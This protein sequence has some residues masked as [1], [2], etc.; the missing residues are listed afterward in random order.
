[1]KKKEARSSPANEDR[2]VAD[3]P[4][5]R[6]RAQA[7]I[8]P[9]TGPAPA[10]SCHS[11]RPLRLRAVSVRL[12]GTPRG[13]VARGSKRPSDARRTSVGAPARPAASVGTRHPRSPRCA[14]TCALG[15]PRRLLTEASGLGA[16]HAPLNH[17]GGT[18]LGCVALHPCCRVCPQN[19]PLP[20]RSPIRRTC[21]AGPPLPRTCCLTG[22]APVQRSGS[23]ASPQVRP[24]TRATRSGHQRS[25]ERHI[26]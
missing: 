4:N 11:G 22:P 21:Q 25:R 15:A 12:G 5:R 17:S 20:T 23:V 19:W 10:V 18:N 7:G 3:V 24:S 14:E 2:A 6:E 9:G 26:A 8:A 13:Q 16:C 1:M